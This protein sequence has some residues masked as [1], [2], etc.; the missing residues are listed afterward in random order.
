MPRVVINPKE[1]RHPVTIEQRREEVTRNADGEEELDEPHNWEVATRGFASIKPLAGRQLV[2]AQ[3]IT[4]S[5]SHL[6]TM[7]FDPLIKAG[8]RVRFGDRLLTINAAID[9]EEL[10]VK[11]SL[12]CTEG[13]VA[14]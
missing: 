9:E 13:T 5:V 12:Y 7:R 14:Q 11:L 6:V 10:N 1:L 2:H 4:T 3:S 8:Q